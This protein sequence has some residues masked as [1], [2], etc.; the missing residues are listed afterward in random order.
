[1]KIIESVTNDF[2]ID[3]N[4]VHCIKT[5]VSTP[6]AFSWFALKYEDWDSKAHAFPAKLSQE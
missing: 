6:K 5:S 3:V 4:R 1:M 2:F